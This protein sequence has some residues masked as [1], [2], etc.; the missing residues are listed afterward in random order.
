[1]LLS[2]SHAAEGLRRNLSSFAFPLPT[3]A[4]SAANKSMALFDWTTMAK[5]CS[6]NDLRV[7]WTGQMSVHPPKEK[8]KKGM[9]KEA[10]RIHQNDKNKKESLTDWVTRTLPFVVPAFSFDPFVKLWESDGR[11]CAT[12]NC[13]ASDISKVTTMLPAS[14]R[15]TS[16]D[17]VWRI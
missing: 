3:R 15:I 5:G 9:V 4:I 8:D 14:H 11:H 1:M 13:D 17:V 16:H 2:A 6:A 12:A 10:K 7:N